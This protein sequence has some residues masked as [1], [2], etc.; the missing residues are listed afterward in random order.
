MLISINKKNVD[1]EPIRLPSNNLFSFTIFFN[2]LVVPYNNIK[3]IKKLIINT[4]SKYIFMLSPGLIY[5][6]KNDLY[7]VLLI[8]LKFLFTL[9]FSELYPKYYH[10]RS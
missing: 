6:I 1:N 3:S 10:H 4:K 5:K 7:V 9:S 2:I 8:L